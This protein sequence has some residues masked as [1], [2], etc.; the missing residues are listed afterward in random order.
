MLSAVG[1]ASLGSI[2]EIDFTSLNG[3][4]GVILTAVLALIMF[5]YKKIFKKPVPVITFIVIS[6]IVGIGANLAV[7]NFIK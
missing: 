5:V 3:W 7:E 6:A 4:L 1:V 2:K